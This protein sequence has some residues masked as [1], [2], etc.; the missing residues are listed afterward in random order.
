M[1]TTHERYSNCPNP[2]CGEPRYA[3]VDHVC[4]QFAVSPDLFKNWH[5][6]SEIYPN[7]KT[8]FTLPKG[9]TST[10]VY[11]TPDQVN[12]LIEDALEPIRNAVADIRKQ[13]PEFCEG[14]DDVLVA[15]DVIKS[16]GFCGRL[17]AHLSHE[18][19]ALSDRLDVMTRERDTAVGKQR[20]LLSE[21]AYWKGYANILQ[22]QA[23]PILNAHIRVLEDRLKRLTIQLFDYLNLSAFK[24]IGE[25]IIIQAKSVVIEQQG[26]KEA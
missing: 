16:S 4:H 9:W 1:T 12:K 26:I 15:V 11:Y 10:S 23:I 17:A 18:R 22:D 25:P 13:D 8:T 5:S 20:A 2:T 14:E 6:Y 3:G 19:I 7:L 24:I 21:V